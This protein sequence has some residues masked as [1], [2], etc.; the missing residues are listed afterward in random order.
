MND[1]VTELEILGIE[2]G[3]EVNLREL[4]RAFKKKSLAMLP[5]KHPT[6]VNA[7]AQF[8]EINTAFVNV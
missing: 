2:E 6:I 8:E 4:R 7:H 1:I 3:T 5:E